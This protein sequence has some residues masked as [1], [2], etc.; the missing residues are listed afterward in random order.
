MEESCEQHCLGETLIPLINRLQDVFLHVRTDMRLD[1]PQVAVVGSQS[2]GKS[3]VLEALVGRDFLPRG[4]NIVTRRP[5]V[6]QLIKHNEPG[7]K[8][9]EW[10]EFLHCRGKK[11]YD[12]ERIRMEIE[13]ETDRSVG[14]EKSISSEPIRLRI[15][16]PRVLTMTLV[17]LPGMTRVPVGDQPEDIERQLRKL[18]L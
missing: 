9:V 7:G 2:S 13:T 10:G 4:N 8:A 16:S 6:L 1:L 11:F 15:F 5:L 17:D 12:F 3:S 18:I 14:T